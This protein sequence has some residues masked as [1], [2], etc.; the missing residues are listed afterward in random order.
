M[1]EPIEF[2]CPCDAIILDWC[3][4]Q[5]FQIAY[6]RCSAKTGHG[7]EEAF[8]SLC[9]RLVAQEMRRVCEPTKRSL[10]D[11]QRLDNS[12]ELSMTLTE[13]CN[14]LSLCETRKVNHK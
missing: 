13:K 9:S 6:S 10:E 5:S 14:T 1:S 2:P 11:S 4:R 3:Q 8:E 7:V 12:L